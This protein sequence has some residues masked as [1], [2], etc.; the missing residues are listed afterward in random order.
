[1]TSPLSEI[2]N[3]SATTGEQ[4]SI[5][6]HRAR[7]RRVNADWLAAAAREQRVSPAL[8]AVGCSYSPVPEKAVE[9]GPGRNAAVAARCNDELLA[10]RATAPA[11]R[12]T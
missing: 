5:Q 8:Q 11:G 2:D 7:G 9:S 1:V 6:A 12:S 3:V 4:L 10:A